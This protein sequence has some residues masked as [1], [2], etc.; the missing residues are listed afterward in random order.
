MNSNSSS[1]GTGDL[2]VGD[3][4]GD[5]LA[6][7]LRIAS[8]RGV[9][10]YCTIAKDRLGTSRGNYERLVAVDQV[11]LQ[12][13]EEAVFLRMR[14]AARGSSSPYTRLY[15]SALYYGGE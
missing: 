13:V 9:H 14:S 1:C 8:V 11:V 3:G 2:A 7:V 6:D 5:L 15:I 10:T 12:M 4:D